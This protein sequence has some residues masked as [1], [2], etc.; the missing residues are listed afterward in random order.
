MKLIE[1]EVRFTK[2]K[3]VNPSQSEK[4]SDARYKHVQCS[5]INRFLQQIFFFSRT[6]LFTVVSVFFPFFLSRPSV[7]HVYISIL[8][9]NF[10][11]RHE[12]N[13]KYG[14]QVK[15]KINATRNEKAPNDE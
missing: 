8:N 2:A 3:P 12:L 6:F 4:S 13:E 7:Q 14:V 15:G 11:F 10:S 5:S 9:R 1:F